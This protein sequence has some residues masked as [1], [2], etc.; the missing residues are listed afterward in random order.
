M[1]ESAFK[2]K[3]IRIIICINQKTTA[4]LFLRI[5]Y[6][7]L[8]IASYSYQCPIKC[9]ELLACQLN[10][11]WMWKA[12][13]HRRHVLAIDIIFIQTDQQQTRK[14]QKPTEFG[15]CVMKIPFSTSL[16]SQWIFFFGS[17]VTWKK[18]NEATAKQNPSFPKDLKFPLNFT[19]WCLGK[20]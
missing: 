16:Y 4:N 18:N 11:T 6:C 8:Q 3:W 9:V 2:I 14:I 5:R 15:M 10:R 20:V 1:L 7:L 13:G 19:P 12:D 17:T